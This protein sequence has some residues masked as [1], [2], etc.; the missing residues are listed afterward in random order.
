MINNNNFFLLDGYNDAHTNLKFVEKHINQN[1]LNVILLAMG[2]PKQ[3]NFAETI[4][5]KFTNYQGCIISGG[6]IVDF[7]GGKIQRANNFLKMIGME[8]FYRFLKEPKRM[9]R[10]Y[11]IGIPLFISRVLFNRI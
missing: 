7:T 5:S 6:A 2:M 4:S 9:F 10:R 1:K 11:I 8:W 3:E